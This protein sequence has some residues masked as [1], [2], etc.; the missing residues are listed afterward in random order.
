MV[1]SV[2]PKQE[3]LAGDDSVVIRKNIDSIEGGRALDVTAFKAVTG[4]SI[5]KA[6]TIIVKDSEGYKP[7]TVVA[8]ESGD[9]TYGSFTA[10]EVVGILSATIDAAHGGASIMIAGKVNKNL[11]PYGGASKVSAIA[12]YV[13][14][15]VFMA[16]GE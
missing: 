16:D 14:H 6:G 15:I 7:A 11:M 2:F 1:E 12:S 4:T 13:P 5:V 3:I 9:I 10:S 8:G